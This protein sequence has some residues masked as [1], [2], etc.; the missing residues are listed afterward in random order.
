M[1][2]K[3]EEAINKIRPMLQADG[4]G[5]AAHDQQ[6]PE[7]GCQ[8]FHGRFGL[9]HGYHGAFQTTKCTGIFRTTR[10]AGTDAV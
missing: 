4:P 2:K 8:F 9:F 5:A 7:Y 3:V 10:S 6:D 1:R